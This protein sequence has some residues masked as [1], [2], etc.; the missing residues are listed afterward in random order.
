MA[1]NVLIGTSSTFTTATNWSTGA[2]PVAT[3]DVFLTNNTVSFTAGLNNATVAS[4]NT[5]NVVMDYTGAMGSNG[6]SNIYLQFSATTCNIGQPIVGGGNANGSNTFNWNAGT[7]SSI[8]NVLNTANSGA[9]TGQAPVKILGSNMT[10]N[11]TGGIISVA[12]LPTETATISTF[13]IANGQTG[14]SPRAFIGPGCNT[15]TLTQNAGAVTNN[16]QMVITTANVARSS[17]TLNHQG[18]G[19]YGTLE[20]DNGASVSYVGTGSISSLILTGTIDFSGGGGPV[21]IVNRT[22]F[23]GAKFVDPSKRCTFTNNATFNG[24]SIS[25]CTIDRGQGGLF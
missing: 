1:N 5:L 20:I 6:T 16:S 7:N 4:L 19:G 2:A 11:L 3:Q 15:T 12:A 17:S 24:C 8:C 21:T 23:R 10:I 25:D 18:T 22:L 14:I 13:T 9:T